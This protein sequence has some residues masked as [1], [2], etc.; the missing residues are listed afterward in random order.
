MR[1]EG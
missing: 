1:C